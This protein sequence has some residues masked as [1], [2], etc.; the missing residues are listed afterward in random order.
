MK[1]KL[2]KYAFEEFDDTVLEEYVEYVK[3]NHIKLS[4]EATAQLPCVYFD[5]QDYRVRVKL[6]IVID[7]SDT[8]KNLLFYDLEGEDVSYDDDEITV[9]IDTKMNK[10]EGSETLFVKEAS[11]SSLLAKSS[12]S[13]SSGVK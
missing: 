6:E 10:N 2:K 7:S 9:Y 5:G 4:G 3:S 13:I 1:R 12:S 11:I 8:D